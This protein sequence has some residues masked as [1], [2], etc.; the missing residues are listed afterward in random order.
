ML[1][2]GLSLGIYIFIFLFT[3][4]SFAKNLDCDDLF[5][6]S[7]LIQEDIDQMYDKEYEKLYPKKDRGIGRD[8]KKVK[9][10]NIGSILLE[11]ADVYDTMYFDEIK[12]DSNSYMFHGKDISYAE[13]MSLIGRLE[14]TLE[15]FADH[16]FL[17]ED[18]LDEYE[19]LQKDPLYK[20]ERIKQHRLEMNPDVTM[21]VV[22][23]V[24]KQISHSS[25]LWQAYI[26]DE[27]Q[28]Y[29]IRSFLDPSRT[30]P[31]NTINF[32]HPLFFK[33]VPYSIHK[34]LVSSILLYFSLKFRNDPKYHTTELL[35]VGEEIFTTKEL[36][37][38]DIEKKKIRY[39][40]RSRNKKRIQEGFRAVHSYG[41]EIRDVVDA[42]LML[43]RIKKMEV[44]NNALKFNPHLIEQDLAFLFKFFKYSGYEVEFEREVDK[45]FNGRDKKFIEYMIN[46]SDIL[47]LDQMY[48]IGS[49]G[50][51][52]GQILDI[53]GESRDRELNPQKILNLFLTLY[54]DGVRVDRIRLAVNMAMYFQ[55][56]FKNNF[57]SSI[58]RGLHTHTMDYN[59]DIYDL[60]KLIL[61]T[62]SQESTVSKLSQKN[63]IFIDGENLGDLERSVKETDVNYSFD[64]TEL[65]EEDLLINL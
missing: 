42:N 55:Q 59:C 14:Q 30:F 57:V 49:W 26:E 11:I 50:F 51:S 3:K 29:D 45:I 4:T 40:I 13:I 46:T 37:D 58:K 63:G 34:K 32:K 38:L 31:K 65:D 9:I 25:T 64:F 27:G 22:F 54:G 28:V 56:R 15:G 48:Y 52:L 21:I 7:S 17:G 10:N 62:L 35:Q 39:D 36:M 20:D 33:Y 44:F 5:S 1:K 61:N 2:R 23:A 6:D 53:L 41:Q 12:Q 19:I 24:L 16:I 8:G 60:N 47:D 43:E 18:E